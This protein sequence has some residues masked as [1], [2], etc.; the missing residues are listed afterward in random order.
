MPLTLVV[1]GLL[2]IVTGVRD[3]YAQFAAQLRQ[4]VIGGGTK[5]FLAYGLAIGAVG[6]VGYV[7]RLRPAANAFMA[8]IVISLIL[9]KRGLIQQFSDALAGGPLSPKVPDT[10]PSPTSTLTPDDSTGYESILG[11]KPQASNTAS[12]GNLANL[13]QIGLLFA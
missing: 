11:N 3:T 12:T 5:S 1:V 10:A 6:A 9:S 7:D 4:D 13:A 2:M 8:L